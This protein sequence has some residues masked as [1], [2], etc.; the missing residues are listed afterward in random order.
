M[1]RGKLQPL[2]A[3]PRALGAGSLADWMQVMRVRLKSSASKSRW[4]WPASR[5]KGSCRL[6]LEVVPARAKSPAYRAQEREG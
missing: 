1:V 3:L 4:C 2:A 5:A 6:K